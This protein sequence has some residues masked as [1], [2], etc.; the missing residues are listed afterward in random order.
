MMMMMM[1]FCYIIYILVVFC[2]IVL[3]LCYKHITVQ[4][5]WTPYI[6]L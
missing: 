4:C 3:W 2:A 5:M 6:D 1:Y